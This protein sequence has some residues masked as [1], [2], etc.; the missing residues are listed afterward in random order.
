MGH[1]RARAL[2][3]LE[4]RTAYAGTAALPDRPAAS[5][6]NAGIPTSD[7]VALLERKAQLESAAADLGLRISVF[8]DPSAI[9]ALDEIRTELALNR[10]GDPPA[11]PGRQ[12]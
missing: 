8:A 5:Q 4:A 10:A 3:G 9:T 7:R 2:R 11:L 12:Q 1:Y 6:A